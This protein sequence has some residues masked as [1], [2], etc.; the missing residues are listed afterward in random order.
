LVVLLE[1]VIPAGLLFDTDSA[2]NRF[3]TRLLITHSNLHFRGGNTPLPEQ[4][5]E[6]CQHNDGAAKQCGARGRLIV[7]QPNP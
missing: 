2:S 4:V 5:A 6:E 3:N 7:N 1:S